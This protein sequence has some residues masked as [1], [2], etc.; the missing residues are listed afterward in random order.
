MVVLMV[1]DGN[2]YYDDY[3]GDD[4]FMDDGDILSIWLYD[5]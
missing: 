4:Y 2:D 3:D 1:M 5:Q